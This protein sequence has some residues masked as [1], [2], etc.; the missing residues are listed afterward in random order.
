MKQIG[1]YTPWGPS[2]TARELAPGITL[3]T[4]A[5]HGG[6]HVELA[7][8]MR[9]PTALRDFQTFTGGNWYEEDCDICLVV[10]ARPDLFRLDQVQEAANFARSYCAHYAPAV[11]K[12]ID[13]DERRAVKIRAMLGEPVPA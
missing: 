1:N 7:E 2:Q 8:V 5:G 4:T 12:W 6:A 11:S 10:L 3:Y 9:W 13:S